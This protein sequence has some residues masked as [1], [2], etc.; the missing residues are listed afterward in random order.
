MNLRKNLQDI[1]KHI[2]SSETLLRL[3]HYNENPLDASKPDIVEG[4]N[5]L[6]IAD[7]HVFWTPKTTDLLLEDSTCRLCVYAGNRSPLN[8]N[9]MSSYQDFVFDI[10]VHIEDFDQKDLR[11]TWI[12]DE[13]NKLIS[14]TRIT[15][16]GK[17]EFVTGNI[18]GDTPDGYNGYKLVYQFGSGN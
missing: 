6:E 4:E 13:I 17:V 11:L 5:Y 1:Y 3:L 15:G 9:Y 8:S 2:I 10:Y 12:A 7:S 14:M 18:I 16:M